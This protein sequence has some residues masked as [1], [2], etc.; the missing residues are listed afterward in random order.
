MLRLAPQK[1]TIVVKSQ[2]ELSCFAHLLHGLP[3]RLARLFDEL[4]LEPVGLER[5]EQEAG[6]DA[7]AVVEA[8]SI[9]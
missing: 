1:V 9:G 6:Y 8:T 4:T 2:H 7:E 3:G 5:V